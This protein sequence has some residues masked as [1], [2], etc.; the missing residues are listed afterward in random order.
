MG[1]RT[2]KKCTDKDL[3]KC[4]KDHRRRQVAENKNHVIIV[5]KI[6]LVYMNKAL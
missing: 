4:T 1:Q 3:Q 6:K 5:G 2:G